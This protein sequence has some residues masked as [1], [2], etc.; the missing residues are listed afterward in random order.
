[1]KKLF[2]KLNLRPLERR[3]L[4][5]GLVVVFLVVQFLYVWPYF[6]AVAKMDRRRED[7]L[8]MLRDYE[9]EFAQTNK[10][11]KLVTELEGEG[12]A[13]LPEDQASDLMRTIVNQSAQAGV[14]ITTSSKPVSRTNDAFFVEQS[15]QISTLSSEDALIAFLHNLGAGSSLIR[16]RDLTLRADPSHMKL[17]STVKLVAS[18][19]RNRTARVQAPA[20][21]SPAPAPAPSKPAVPAPASKA[22]KTSTTLKK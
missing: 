12:G 15:I 9:A 14:T 17:T 13:V 3:L 18:Y 6:G 11:R 7:G 16:V 21:K 4:V 1:M 19:Q 10:F 5:G 2:D 22:N 20:A 8:K